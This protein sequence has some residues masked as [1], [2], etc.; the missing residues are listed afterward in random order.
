[1]LAGRDLIWTDW[2]MQ[3]QKDLNA[4]LASLAAA[5][6]DQLAKARFA[7]GR[8]QAVKNLTRQAEQERR[9]K[10]KRQDQG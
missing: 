4:R 6:E 5:R 9:Q 7:L 10:Q 8:A 2:V 3:Q 1:M